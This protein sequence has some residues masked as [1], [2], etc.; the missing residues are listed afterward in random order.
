MTWRFHYFVNSQVTIIDRL[1]YCCNV[2][3][4]DVFYTRYSKKKSANIKIQYFWNKHLPY[5]GLYYNYNFGFS[6]RRID[7][8]YCTHQDDIQLQ[9]HV[10]FPSYIVYNS[11]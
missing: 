3:Q 6:P 11:L 8:Q 2:V 5:F 4:L 1:D 9:Q 7:V 10:V